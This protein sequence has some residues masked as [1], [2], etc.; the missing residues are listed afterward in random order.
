MEMPRKNSGRP[1]TPLFIIIARRLRELSPLRL[2][3]LVSIIFFGAANASASGKLGY[4]CSSNGQCSDGAIC[5][6]QT[7]P[8]FL[9]LGDCVIKWPDGIKISFTMA[10]DKAQ[11]MD[12]QSDRNGMPLEN[13]YFTG[14]ITS[15]KVAHLQ[16]IL[17]RYP[18]RLPVADTRTHFR[19]LIDSPGGDVYAAMEL[20]RLL[21]ANHVFISPAG[22][23]LNNGNGYCASA[24]VLAWVGAPVRAIGSDQSLFIIHRP[25]GFADAGQDLAGSSMRWK[26]MQ[27]DIRRYLV[28]MNIPPT[29]LDAMNEVPSEEGRALTAAEWS[30]YLIDANDPAWEEL[31]NAQAAARIG[32]SRVEY[33]ELTARYNKCMETDWR[34]IACAQIYHEAVY[35]KLDQAVPDWE[36]INKSAAFLAWLSQTDVFAGTTRRQR[37]KEAFDKNDSARVVAIFKEYVDAH[38]RQARSHAGDTTAAQ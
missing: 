30:R 23:P 27:D 14:T 26:T 7:D 2:M 38:S 35:V 10:F 11:G 3:L 5:E 8:F 37:L 13:I 24:C 16:Q 29:L 6:L 21:R 32:V 4:G 34:P 18:P 20:G 36:E 17:A 22:S 25:Y 9:K 15:Q 12:R 33:N 19:L 31:W 28:E 1:I